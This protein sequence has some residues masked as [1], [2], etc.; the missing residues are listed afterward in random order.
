M[1]LKDSTP[2]N[3]H[4]SPPPTVTLT[5]F[6]SIKR[7]DAR[8]TIELASSNR[9]LRFDKKFPPPS[10]AGHPRHLFLTSTGTLKTGLSEVCSSVS[11]SANSPVQD[12]DNVVFGGPESSSIGGNHVDIHRVSTSTPSCRPGVS[13]FKACPASLLNQYPYWRNGILRADI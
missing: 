1:D 10:N 7:K 9:S 12:A 11:E 6:I 3:I 5:L 13:Q 8:F 4:I 2:V